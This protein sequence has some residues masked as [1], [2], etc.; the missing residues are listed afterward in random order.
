MIV[1]IV[2]VVQDQTIHIQMSVTGVLILLV[3]V[4]LGLMNTDKSVPVP[5]LARTPYA[6]LK[7]PLSAGTRASTSGRRGG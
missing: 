4:M 5:F 1:K 6:V 2:L 7:L 3:L